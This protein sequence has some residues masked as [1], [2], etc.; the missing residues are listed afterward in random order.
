VAQNEGAAAGQGGGGNGAAKAAQSGST[1]GQGG[2]AGRQGGAPVSQGSTQAT[3]DHPAHESATQGQAKTPAQPPVRARAQ[4][5]ASGEDDS[6]RAS[7]EPA[8][9]QTVKAPR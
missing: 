3:A 4:G 6:A 9:A 8:P 2:A 1:A 7:A 5:T